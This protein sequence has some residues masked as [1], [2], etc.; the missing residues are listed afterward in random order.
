[1]R[2]L[3]QGLFALFIFSAAPV[4]AQVHRAEGI[5]TDSRTGE[6]L[7]FVAVGIEGQQ[8]GT[9]TDIDGKFRI[10]STQPFSRLLINYLGYKSTVFSIGPE[11][12][13]LSIRL[14]KS[15]YDLREVV[16]VAGENP[17]NRI[18]LKAVENKDRNNPENLSSFSYDTYNKFIYTIDDYKKPRRSRSDSSAMRLEKFLEAQ[19]LFMM[20]SVTNRRF[21][22]PEQSKETVLATKVSGIQEPSFAMLATEFQ[23]F[24]FYTG[25]IKVN[26]KNYINPVSKGTLNRYFFLLE[27]T[28]F[29]GS[30]TVF[31]ISFRPRKG[32]NFDALQG[33]LY[34]STNGYAIQ[35]VIAEPVDNDAPLSNNSVR[36]AIK[37]QQKYELVEGRQWF[38]IQLNADLA[39]KSSV[40]TGRSV[41]INGISR[42]YIRN[43]RI[44]PP[45]SSRDFDQV[46]LDYAD[47]SSHKDEAF[48]QRYRVD[49]LTRKE[50]RTYVA[51]DSIGKKYKLDKKVKVLEY[52]ARGQIAAGKISFDLN[53]FFSYTI[54]EG[55][56][57]GA[58]IH[59]NE[60]FSRRITLGGYAGYGFGDRVLKYGGDV[61]LL[62]H[63]K[64]DTRIAAAYV[65]D[66]SE[67][68][69]LGFFQDR[70]AVLSNENF[71]GYLVRVADRIEK[72]EIA[73]SSRSIR[74]VSWKLSARQYTKTVTDEYTFEKNDSLLRSFAFTEAELAVRFAFREAYIRSFDQ[75]TPI[76]AKYPVV[77]MQLRQSL[78][79]SGFEY[80]QLDMKVDQRFFIRGLGT[81]TVQLMGGYIFG[82]LP[83]SNSYV[84]KASLGLSRFGVRVANSFQTM[85]MNEFLSDRFVALFVA[86][87]FGKLLYKGK[88]FQ[89]QLEI[90][91]NLC[92]GSLSNRDAHSGRE[93]KTLEK[94][95]FEAGIGVNN[96]YK[97]G[98]YGYGL[99]LFYRYGSQAYTREFNNFAFLLTYVI[100]I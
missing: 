5:I 25:T 41:T 40:D 71:R 1:M 79:G 20:E 55:L 59:T 96:L 60:A 64:S 37:I 29:E 44:N 35:N 83:Y 73:L 39:V 67:S 2:C 28:V 38:P 63:R 90:S 87:N 50:K 46:A 78:P 26:N 7:A 43:I 23:S 3:I 30:D 76:S 54:Y 75:L 17:A 14:E 11:A 65:N 36:L 58:G 6:A 10:Q 88:K 86:H 95:Y 47:S 89:P 82:S 48:W 84:G 15:T 69:G 45:F 98:F 85:A 57:L 31:V 74:Y 9:T 68:G 42:S 72:N 32:K 13:N 21:L 52:L 53:R 33:A 16:V 22:K 12:N 66:I 93:F 61:S 80:T 100:S 19:H 97:S 8:K 49:S 18:I 81:P 92:F 70:R 51:I 24:S 4:L 62:L 34:I 77:W 91:N 27:D 99:G 94:G 56:R